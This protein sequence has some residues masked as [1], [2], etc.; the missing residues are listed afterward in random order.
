MAQL[1]E[2][3]RYN[4]R[5]IAGTI[6]DGVIRNFHLQNPSGRIMTV[7]RTPLVREMSTRN[8]SCG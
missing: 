1:F 8:F 2:A 4:F 3:Q 6:H 7:G 5:K